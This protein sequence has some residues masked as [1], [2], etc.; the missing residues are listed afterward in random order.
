MVGL[1][2]MYHDQHWASDV[3]AGAFNGLNAFA[4][5]VGGEPLID[6]SV[7]DVLGI[8]AAAQV[9]ARRIPV[10]GGLYERRRDRVD[11]ESDIDN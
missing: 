6:R 1:S 9:L 8:N 4:T 7:V 11:V 3:G 2:R 10:H 5:A